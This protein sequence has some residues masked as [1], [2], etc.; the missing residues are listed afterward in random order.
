VG[1]SGD[2]SRE[3][4]G[5]KNKKKKRPGKKQKKEKTIEV[6]KVAEE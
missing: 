1:S 4:Q 2:Q 6:K 5:D 3:N